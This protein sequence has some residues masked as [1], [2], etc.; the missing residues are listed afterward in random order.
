MDALD[1]QVERNLKGR[2][3]EKVGKV[4]EAIRLYE[5]NISENFDGNFPYDRLATIYRKRKDFQS[6]VRVLGKA[7]WVFENVV[8]RNRSDKSPKLQKFKDRLTK[9]LVAAKRS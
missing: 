3:L 1:V 4:D 2:E 5:T 9:A 6:E 7:V 8:Y